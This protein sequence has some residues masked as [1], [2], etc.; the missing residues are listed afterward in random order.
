[1]ALLTVQQVTLAGLQPEFTPADV[2]GDQAPMDS[3]NVFVVVRNGGASDVDVTIN[4]VK[5][6]DQG[7][8]HDEVVTVPAG[9]EAWIGGSKFRRDRFV[10]SQ[11]RVS[12]TYSDTASV[13]VAAFRL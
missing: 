9:E 3:D 1:M 2:A 12:W 8:D 4:S 7:F 11:G 13:T 6:C 10:D 5:P